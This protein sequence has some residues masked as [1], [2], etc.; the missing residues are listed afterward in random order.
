M[1]EVRGLYNGLLVRHDLLPHNAPH[2]PAWRIKGGGHVAL[3]V[4]RDVLAAYA[5]RRGVR[6]ER[7]METWDAA[8]LAQAAPMRLTDGDVY[9]LTDEALRDD[10]LAANLRDKMAAWPHLDATALRSATA[11]TRLGPGDA[12]GAQ[13]PRDTTRVQLD[14]TTD[15]AVVL[16]AIAAWAHEHRA[17]LV[18]PGTDP[19]GQ[20]H[21]VIDRVPVLLVRSNITMQL[22]GR[23]AADPRA[24]QQAW[25]ASGV[26]AISN[27]PSDQHENRFTVLVSTPSHAGARLRYAAFSWASLETAGLP[28][29]PTGTLGPSAPSA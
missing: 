18:S 8:G 12:R 10:R 20:W 27:S 26:L 23:Y 6:L 24:V 9:L 3:A 15:P 13:P 14:T 1:D 29:D 17:E 11:Q 25:K 19:I 28:R 16:R 21:T 4:R 5:A 7:M 2:P 22:L